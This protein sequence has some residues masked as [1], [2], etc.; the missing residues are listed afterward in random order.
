MTDLAPDARL[1]ILSSAMRLF[2]EATGDLDTLAQVVVRRVAEQLGGYCGLG[3]VSS[4]GLWLE[5]LASWDADAAALEVLRRRFQPARLPVNQPQ[6][7]FRAVLAGE[8]LVFAHFD[9]ATLLPLV[10]SEEH[11]GLLRLQVQSMLYAPLRAGG[12][13]I[14]LLTLLRHGSGAATFD[15][16]DRSLAENL[17]DLAAL[18]IS[19]ARLIGAERKARADAE[20]ALAER[21]RAG[22]A[23]RLAETL[24]FD[25]PDAVVVAT[26]TGEVR[27][28]NGQA[29]RLFGYR[30]DE[31]VGRQGLLVPERL[32]AEAASRRASFVAAGAAGAPSVTM[33][34]ELRRKDGSEFKAEVRVAAVTIE[35]ETLL[36]A[37]IRDVSEARRAETAALLASKQKSELLATLSHELRT[38]LSA[39][40]GFVQLLLL[41]RAGAV[42][43]DQ[44]QALNDVLTSSE[45]LLRLIGEALDLARVELG[46]LELHPERVDP[47]QLATEVRDGLRPIAD[48]RR[49]TVELEPGPSL[50]HAFIDPTRVK[51]VLY[52]F[53]ANALQFTPGGG[54]VKLRVGLGTGHRFRLEVEDTGVGIPP[55]VLPTLFTAFQHL[56][57]PPEGRAPGTGLG[58]ALSRRIAEE[59]GGAVGVRSEPAVGS[60]FWVELPFQ[61]PASQLG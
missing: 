14:G 53:L 37:V 54:R 2:A 12:R 43:A 28:L 4:D 3:L 16:G 23:L 49:V 44:R 45:H 25:A 35:G 47:R 21:K 22:A 48:Q 7:P 60:T 15:S 57:P 19:N 5:P 18:T 58:L 50:A 6:H 32:H 1:E 34:W 51:Q 26:A 46:R 55:E 13:V 24:L 40:I 27:L 29:E 33:E 30:A 20:R 17:A 31:V 11:A 52:N 8:T 39:I 10:P 36:S 42:S 38:P 56:P 41:G 9:A 61:P 59:L